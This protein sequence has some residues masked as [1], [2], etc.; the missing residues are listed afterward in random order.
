MLL[1]YWF[2]KSTSSR[3]RLTSHQDSQN[4]M[5]HQAARVRWWQRLVVSRGKLYGYPCNML[6]YRTNRRLLVILTPLYHLPSSFF[7]WDLAFDWAD[8]GASLVVCR[9]SEESG[10]SCGRM[11]GGMLDPDRM[12]K[13]SLSSREVLVRLQALTALALKRR[14]PYPG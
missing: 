11:W 12:E 8:S 4:H 14:L 1:E 10:A 6:A 3:H 9:P 7:F 2:A 5:A 13:L